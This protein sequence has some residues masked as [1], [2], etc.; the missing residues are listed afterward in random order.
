MSVKSHNIKHDTTA[1]LHKNSTELSKIL[2]SRYEISHTEFN[3][4]QEGIDFIKQR[5]FGKLFIHED[6]KEPLWL[7]LDP[8]NKVNPVMRAT[9]YR[10]REPSTRYDSVPYT[11]AQWNINDVVINSNPNGTKNLYWVCVEAG[12]PGKWYTVGSVKPYNS[13]IEQVTFLPDTNEQQV[14]RQ[15]MFKD[16][17]GTQQIYFCAEVNGRKQ[18]IPMLTQE[19]I[20]LLQGNYLTEEKAKVYVDASKEAV[21]GTN[22][23]SNMDYEII[24]FN[25]DYKPKVVIAKDLGKEEMTLTE[26]SDAM[27]GSTLIVPLDSSY[28]FSDNKATILDNNIADSDTFNYITL[29]ERGELEDFSTRTIP[30]NNLGVECVKRKL[31]FALGKKNTMNMQSAYPGIVLSYDATKKQFCVISINKDHAS[32]SNLKDNLSNAPGGYITKNGSSRNSYMYHNI[33]FGEDL[34]CKAFLVFSSEYK[35]ITYP[36]RDNGAISRLL[37]STRSWAL[38]EMANVKAKLE[39]SISSLRNTSFPRVDKTNGALND[40]T[41]FNQATTEGIYRVHCGST[42]IKNGPLGQTRNSP[43][44]EFGSLMVINNKGTGS[45]NQFFVTQLFFYAGG[46]IYY[47][48][49]TNGYEWSPWQA[50]LRSV[51]N[52]LIGALSR[53]GQSDL[54]TGRALMAMFKPYLDNTDKGNGSTNEVG[55]RG[56]FISFYSKYTIKHQPSQHGTLISFGHSD[57]EVMQMWISQPD[58]TIFT[59]AGNSSQRI[60]DQP[61]RNANQPAYDEKYDVLYAGNKVY[62]DSSL[63]LRAA[64]GNYTKVIIW[65]GAEEVTRYER[66][67]RDDSP[68]E[69]REWTN[70]VAN[71]DITFLRQLSN[72]RYTLATS[73]SYNRAFSILSFKDKSN[74]LDRTDIYNALTSTDMGVRIYRIQGYPRKF[75]YD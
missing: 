36:H 12:T 18:W 38:K 66:G 57:W 5:G 51:S 17:T 72:Y 23:G 32:L 75:G 6:N 37:N 30:K 35:I 61:F 67:G 68:R 47:R 65:F 52:G 1:N 29:N 34:T 48:Y 41:D 20:R 26:A 46:G 49:Q 39:N 25:F 15:V 42:D 70:Y 28:I 73:G 3:N 33:L 31:K 22:N 62:Y 7:E 40:I 16:A 55:G 60:D 58:G 2:D 50:L 11:E 74:W 9:T 10:N 4:I 21:T 44:E 56:F 63:N 69:F 59:R 13:Y 64:L 19:S 24:K 45:G 54:E 53:F 71:L 43:K 27:E 14:G 8:T